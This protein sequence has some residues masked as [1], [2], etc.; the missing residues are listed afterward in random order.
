[1]P[2]APHPFVDA[3]PFLPNATALRGL[4]DRDGYLFLPGAADPAIVATVRGK[5]AQVAARLGLLAA[6]QP[7]E[8]C[9][10]ARLGAR[11]TGTGYDDPRWLAL[12]QAILV[13]PDLLTLG[14]WPLV[15]QTLATL[16]GEPVQ[17]R[18]GDIVRLALPQ[19]PE[20]TT[21]PHQDHFYVGGSPL[22]WTAWW[23]LVPCALPQGPLVLWPGSHA[24]GLL[25]HQGAGAGRQ[26]VAD[27]DLPWHSSEMQ[28]GDVVLFA[29]LTVHAALENR[30]PTLARVSADFRYQPVSHALS[31]V[32]VDGT[33][34]RG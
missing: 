19:Q 13:D 16:Y 23:P 11:L 17:T 18:R 27:P 20:L 26:G 15:L 22:V 6:P 30:S 12:Q 14:D 8:T 1:M 7:G 33:N 5:V 34:A 24:G 32:R 21:P 3:T 29:C 4:A 28:P 31:T 9:L 25:P 2:R 10:R